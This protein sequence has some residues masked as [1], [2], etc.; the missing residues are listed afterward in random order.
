MQMCFVSA[1][2]GEQLGKEAAGL[3]LT[4]FGQDHRLCLA[5]GIGDEPYL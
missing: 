2:G 4:L 3:A 5:H 1:A